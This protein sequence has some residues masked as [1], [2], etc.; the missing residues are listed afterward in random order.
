MSERKASVTAHPVFLGVHAAT[1]ALWS[2]L[3]QY[4]LSPT[5]RYTSE[6]RDRLQSIRAATLPCGHRTCAREEASGISHR[7]AAT[8]IG[9]ERVR[10]GKR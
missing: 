7:A 6:V 4:A 5:Y 1:D 2:D 8:A 10:L 9:V 3:Q